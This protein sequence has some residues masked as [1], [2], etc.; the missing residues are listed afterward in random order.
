MAVYF[1]KEKAAS[2]FPCKYRLTIY[3]IEYRKAPHLPEG[4]WGAVF[5]FGIYFACCSQ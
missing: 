5:P 2:G 3:N 4:K 1:W